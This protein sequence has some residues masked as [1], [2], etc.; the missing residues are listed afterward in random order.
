MTRN[1]ALFILIL[2]LASCS[3]SGQETAPHLQEKA[4]KLMVKNPSIEDFFK[5]DEKGV[6]MYASLQAKKADS[7]EIFLAYHEFE[8]FERLYKGLNRDSSLQLYLQK[9]NKPYQ[10]FLNQQLPPSPQAFAPAKDSLLPLKGLRVALDPGHLGGSMEMA[11][12]EKKYVKIKADPKEGIPYEV[13]F[14]EGN[15]ALATAYLLREKLQKAGAEVL[16]TR[17]G[18]GKSSFGMT[19]ERWFRSKKDSTL[20]EYAKSK[21]LSSED[22]LWWFTQATKRQIYRLPFL[23]SEFNHRANLIHD[24]QPHL[25][26]I[27]HYNVEESNECDRAGWFKPQDKNYSMAFVPGSYM[28][29]EL[30]TPEKRFEFLARLIN[31]DIDES[32]KLSG[33]VVQ[34]FAQQLDVPLMEW[35]DSL[36][37]LAKASLQTGETAVFARNL[38]LCR[39]IPG[40]IC[41]G[42]SL[43]QDNRE[44]CLR[45]NSRDFTIE[46]LAAPKRVKTVAEAYFQGVLDY[47]KL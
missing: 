25:T 30:K 14:N 29:G 9:G 34:Q 19:F 36:R 46:G 44:E 2:S 39:L 21:E 12:L 27:I 4:T 31:S 43:L 8:T 47:W 42:E 11:E 10:D 33:A 23:W 28:D 3:V 17:E 24:F 13:A 6:S 40:V 41:F 22:S 38:S 37:Y 45:L 18:K 20:R 7:A 35:S 15:L 5:I 16:L 32:I 1:L 26:L